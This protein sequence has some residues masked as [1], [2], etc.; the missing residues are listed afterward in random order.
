[1][2]RALAHNRR[3]PTRNSA[4]AVSR[5]HGLCV[6]AGLALSGCG[7]IGYDPRPSGTD[8]AGGGA[9]PGTEPSAQAGPNPASPTLN[10][11]TG[12]CLEVEWRHNVT[13]L[14]SAYT[15]THF[16][17]TLSFRSDGS[18]L[19]TGSQRDALTWGAVEWPF[20]ADS[21]VVLAVG[22]EGDLD[23]IHRFPSGLSLRGLVP[24]DADAYMLAGFYWQQVDLQGSSIP[25]VANP[26]VSTLFSRIDGS[27]QAQWVTSASAPNGPFMFATALHGNAFYG[28]GVFN[29]SAH[30]APSFELD[31]GPD[32]W[33]AVL[34]RLDLT[35]GEV[36]EVQ[37]PF[38]LRH[39]IVDSLL[40]LSAGGMLIHG[41]AFPSTRIGDM[42]ETL[43]SNAA[44]L[45]RTDEAGELV[46]FSLVDTG[47]HDRPAGLAVREPHVS[48]AVE[49]RGS[50]WDTGE[51][52]HTVLGDTDIA[53]LGYSLDG[54]RQWQRVFSTAGRDAALG[55]AISPA[56]VT[57]I[58]L[59][60][61]APLDLT[62]DGAVGR[63]LEAGTAL[64]AINAQG[65][66]V[67]AL[68]WPGV[69]FEQGQLA[70]D[71]TGT[72]LALL[73]EFRNSVTDDWSVQEEDDTRGISLTLFRLD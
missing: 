18:L 36:L 32:G 16:A 55:I 53:V 73:T 56:G 72:R 14:R 5:R 40:P 68:N 6:L 13:G 67:E 59:S 11:P 25:A 58:A 31:V 61:P 33:G 49:L 1:M 51:S 24:V 65:Q 9:F 43:T 47:G 38:G 12:V 57:Y 23:D 45:A 2:P 41:A 52:I 46:W 4:Y 30:W 64:L 39:G 48:I 20:E 35:S 63:V 17:H 7:F 27:G 62:G 69:F 22:P 70:L 44:Y 60:L 15:P 54:S 37:H 50:Q 10:C 71:P 34:S 29:E 66:V 3:A 19:F 21:S 42:D 28:G 8:A 26:S